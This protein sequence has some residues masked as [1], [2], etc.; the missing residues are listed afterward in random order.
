[1]THPKKSIGLRGFSAYRL[2]TQLPHLEISYLPDVL[3]FGAGIAIFYGVIVVGR[4]WMGAFT[5][6]VEIVHL[7]YE[8]GNTEITSI[9][10]EPA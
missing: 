9:C 8:E 1:M 5:P 10:G 7:F 2:W 6:E 3:M 4:T